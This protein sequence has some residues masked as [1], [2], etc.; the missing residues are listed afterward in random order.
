MALQRMIL[1]PPE[2]WEKRC[3]TP[4]P[5]PVKTILKSKDHS[6]NKWTR[7]RL[8]QDPYLKTE[9]LKRESIP[10]PI[11]ETTRKSGPFKLE[12]ELDLFNSDKMLINGVDMN[13][14][15]TRTPEAF[16]LLGPNDDAKVRIK[17][18]DATLFITQVELKPPL[19][20]AHAN[21]LAMK[22]KAHY[23]VTHRQIKTFT[24]RSG[25]QQISIN[26]AFLGPVPDRIL[27]V[28]VKN[29]AFVGSASTN[30]F[31]FHHYDM[32]NLVLY[33]NGVQ[34]PSEPI[35][36]GLLFTLWSCKRL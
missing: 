15:L 7:V 17:I 21:V 14:K 26:N 27:K 25:T 31:H 11:I 24:A 3:E 9:E 13:I 10:I 5:P 19:L 2:L 30:P 29:A 32:T 35:Y 12:P 18:L 23:P 22:R 1:V 34:H 33:I 8:H 16:Y 4:S 36:Y 6:Y 20:L 28:L